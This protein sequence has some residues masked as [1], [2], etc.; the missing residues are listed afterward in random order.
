M[1]DNNGPKNSGGSN[2]VVQLPQQCPVSQCGK[3][4]K[5]AGFC[6]EHFLWFKEGLINRKGEKPSDFDKKYQ[7]FSRRHKTAA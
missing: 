7:A 1:A 2:N 6:D 4:P 3:K 5:R